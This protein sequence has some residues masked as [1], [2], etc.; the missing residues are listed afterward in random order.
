LQRS[1]GTIN[2]HGFTGAQH[3]RNLAGRRLAGGQPAVESVAPVSLADQ[4]ANLDGEF[5]A[6]I[7]ERRGVA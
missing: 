1:G 4:H 3:V 6:R 7:R 2:E 5:L